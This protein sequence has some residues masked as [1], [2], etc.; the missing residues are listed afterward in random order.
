MADAKE[1]E[2]KTEKRPR[3]EGGEETIYEKQRAEGWS[4]CTVI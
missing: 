1:E 2:T 4:F 3:E